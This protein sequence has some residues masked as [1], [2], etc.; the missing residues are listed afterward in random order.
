[1][2]HSF[3]YEF[4]EVLQQQLGFVAELLFEEVFLAEHDIQKLREMLVLVPV[5]LHPSRLA[6][7][8]F[9][10]AK[11][12]A[13]M[14]AEKY[15]LSCCEL[16]ERTVPTAVQMELGREQRWRNVE[17]CF[18]WNPDY[19]FPKFVNKLIILVDDVTTTGA[20]IQ[21]C[22]RVLKQHEIENVVGFVLAHGG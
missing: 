11:V 12:I 21:S 1:M 7:R 22:W 8:G 9:N 3:K 4:V 10:Q 14:L 13:E 18:A 15:D 16:L 2:I 6:W 20:T 5:P 19:D 17:K